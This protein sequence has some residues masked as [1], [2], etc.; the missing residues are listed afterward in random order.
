MASALGNLSLMLLVARIQGSGTSCIVKSTLTHEGPTST[1]FVSVCLNIVRVYNL[2]VGIASPLQL[3][4]QNML[5]G[6]IFPKQ[7]RKHHSNLRASRLQP[8]ITNKCFGAN[9]QRW[10]SHFVVGHRFSVK[11]GRET[12][13]L[14]QRFHAQCD[15]KTNL[16]S[17]TYVMGKQRAIHILCC[18]CVKQWYIQKT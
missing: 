2:E 3:K 18:F 13:S 8:C 1:V 4:N 14:N 15:I 7:K 10:Y 16:E 5:K 6:H 11:M 9:P 17:L 12:F